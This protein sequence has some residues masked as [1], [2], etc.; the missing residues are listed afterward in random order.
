MLRE[1]PDFFL[2][3]L[4]SWT[5]G[6]AFFG[7]LGEMRFLVRP[8]VMREKATG[9]LL[10][11]SHVEVLVWRGEYCLEES[12]VL[13]RAEFPLTEEGHEQVIGWLDGQYG[14]ICP[15]G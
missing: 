4:H 11:G 5:N 10:A 6:N 7:S 1:N 12:E 15:Q 3:N 9:E 14:A 13:D 2:T 8:T